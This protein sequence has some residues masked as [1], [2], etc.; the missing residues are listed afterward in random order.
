VRA[1][2]LL[3]KHV[4]AR[5]ENHL[6]ELLPRKDRRNFLAVCEPVELVMSA[7]LCEPGKP[8]RHA[9]FPTH[10]FV[11]LLT[12]VDDTS[13]LEVGM[14]GREGMLGVQLALG[15]SIT[16]LRGLVQGAGAAW[17]IGADELRKQFAVSPALRR[18]IQ[19]YV[20]VLMMQFASSAA[21]VRFHRIDERLARW[22]LMTHDRAHA[23]AFHVTHEFLAFMLGVR[24]VGI[25]SAAGVLQRRGLIEYRRGAVSVLDRQGL[26]AASC[27]CYAT[28]SAAYG[29]WLS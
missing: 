6:I 9:Y 22:L 18:N 14:V 8:T 17:R 27:S 21:C 15:A 24:R 4:L 25:T 3:G 23:D 28:D 19:L 1:I 16:P 7:V 10:S 20:Y 29:R 13:T 2:D 12:L 26:E 11:S 5:A